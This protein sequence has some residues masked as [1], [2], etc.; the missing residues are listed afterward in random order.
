MNIAV[1]TE[2]CSPRPP[3]TRKRLGELLLAARVLR[4]TDI[5]RIVAAQRERQQRFGEVAL[6]LKLVTETQLRSALAQQADYPLVAHGESAFS[7]TL[8]AAYEPFS[9]YSEGLRTLRSQLLLRCFADDRAAL[10]VVSARSGEGCSTVAANLAIVFAQLGT[11]TLLIDANLRAPSQ[12]QLF[13]VG[14]DMGLADLLQ[15][16]CIAEEVLCPIAPFEKLTLLPAGAPPP[17]PQELLSG[18][19]FTH[20]IDEAS[21]QF[22]VVIIDTPPLLDCAD[23][24]VVALRTRGCVLSA[25]RHQTSTADIQRARASL[26][27]GG[28]ALLGVIINE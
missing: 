28:V 7:H 2:H 6:A 18:D 16:H 17:N 26:V 4:E 9:A 21:Q 25:R 22:E 23:A 12:H 19:A 15:G 27:P 24:A 1:D 13:G 14:G 5:A 11:S 20:L 3:R 8:A 10:A